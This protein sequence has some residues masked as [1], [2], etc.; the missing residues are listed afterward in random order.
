M[1]SNFWKNKKILVTGAQ[2]FLGKHLVKNLLENRRVLKENLFLPAIEELDLRRWEDCKSAVENKDMVIHLA[3][4]T[5]N[6][7]FHR[8]NQGKTFYDN[9]IMGVQLMEAARQ[10]GIKKFVSI[11][12]VT[13]YPKKAPFPFREDGLWEGYPEE[14]HAPYSFAKMMLLV[15]GK[16]YRQQYNFNAIHLLL[17]NMFGPG[18]SMGNAVIPSVIKK[19]KEAKEAK[20][21]FIELWGTGRPT[22]DFLYVEDAVEGILL[23]AEKYDKSEPV[24]IGSG[25][26]LSI[27]SLADIICRLMS[28]SGKVVWD[29]SKPDGQPRWLMDTSLAKKEFGFEAK[30]AI[31]EGLIKTINYE[32]Q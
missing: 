17:T 1:T 11:G 3:A 30:T 6:A 7:E 15:Q 16:A 29:A 28:F 14:I 20:R 25:K 2:G 4:V 19:I 9:L 23:A 32:Q 21:E 18:T 13:E 8:V 12:S 24:N 31:E 26:E 10:A 5:G 22:R 27:K